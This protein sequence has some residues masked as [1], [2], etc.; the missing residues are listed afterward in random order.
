MIWIGLLEVPRLNS[1]QDAYLLFPGRDWHFQKRPIKYIL[2]WIKILMTSQT[3]SFPFP[4]CTCPNED[5]CKH[6]FQ[7][8]IRYL[9]KKCVTK[10][11]T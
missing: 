9:L 3:L 2:A 5:K 4:A 7:N 10:K 11:C 8:W 1:V 6:L